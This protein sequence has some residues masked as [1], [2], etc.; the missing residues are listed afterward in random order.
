MKTIAHYDQLV[1]D[2]QRTARARRNL[3]HAVATGQTDLATYYQGVLTRGRPGVDDLADE[4]DDGLI[5]LPDGM[6]VEVGE[7]LCQ[8][9]SARRLLRR[10]QHDFRYGFFSVSDYATG[11][12]GGEIDA[13]REQLEV[14]LA[15]VW[16]QAPRQDR[17]AA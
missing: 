8:L 17:R 7:R 1:I 11:T 14:D 10:L 2:P 16:V 15:D 12:V 4:F 13:L 9:A 6:D 5:D 3:A